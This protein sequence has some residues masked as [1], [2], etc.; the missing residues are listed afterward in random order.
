M[1]GTGTYTFAGSIGSVRLYNI[2]FSS[3]Q[4]LQ[5]YNATKYRFE[6]ENQSIVKPSKKYGTT[7]AESFTVTSG[8]DTRTVTFNTGN[9]SGIAWDTTTVASRVDLSIQD[10]LNVGTY[11]DTVTVTDSLGQS[12]YLPLKM[13]V[14]KADSLTVSM[15]TATTVSYNGSPITIYPR[16]TIKGLKSSDTAT[17]AVRFS[18]SLYSE[19]TVVPTNAD[20]YTVRGTEPVIT[21]GLL[22]N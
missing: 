19:S 21:I 1:G 13:S 2:P 12:T 5:N 14:T 16:T 10:S 18:S 8:F 20:T 22:Y 17:S 4:V 9:R 3:A 6:T 7:V 11:Y 15:D